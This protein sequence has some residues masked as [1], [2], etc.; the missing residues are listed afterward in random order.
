MEP[1]KKV[2]VVLPG[3]SGPAKKGVMP[4]TTHT[5]DIGTDGWSLI[6]NVRSY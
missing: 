6:K 5:G 4:G 3:F 1:A 2:D